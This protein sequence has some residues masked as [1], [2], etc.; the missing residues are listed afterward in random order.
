MKYFVSIYSPVNKVY[1]IERTHLNIQRFISFTILYLCF[2]QSSTAQTINVKVFDAKNNPLPDVVVYLEPPQGM[3]VEQSDTIIEIAQVDKSFS[4]YLGV[5]QKG[6]K[7]KFHN[8]DDISHQIYSPVGENKFAFKISAGEELVKSNFINVGAIAMGCNIH[9]W[10]SGHL[11]VLDTPYFAK[12]NKQG[13]VSIDI[14]ESGKY[15]LVVWHP[16][17]REKNQRMGKTI[18]SIDYVDKN[19]LVKISLLKSLDELPS[20]KNDDDFDFLSDY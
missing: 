14:A 16:Q 11:L 1:I 2:I 6:T 18:N 10:M 4:P 3:V 8:K 13:E 17:M 9:D 12:T 7:V 5:I 19:S 20:Q 15:N